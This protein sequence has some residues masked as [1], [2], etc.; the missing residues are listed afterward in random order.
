MILV[1][2]G[3]KAQL[4]KMAPIIQAL[5]KY[6]L[7][8]DF[9]LT[10]Q[11]KETMTDLIN[12]FGLPQ[13]A[14]SLTSVDEANTSKKLLHWLKTVLS[15]GLKSDS[16]IRQNGYKVCLVHGDTLS[17]LICAVL[18]KRHGI[19]IAHV[20]AGLRSFNYFHPFPEELTRLAVTKFSD[21]FYCAG[22][23]A[24]NNAERLAKADA[25]IVDIGHNTLLDSV[26][27]AHKFRSSKKA[28]EEPYAIASIHRFENLSNKARFNF[29]M[30]Q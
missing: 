27:Y 6:Q 4:V 5:E 1:P 30:E 19:K 10:G 20:E 26:Q 2:V 12:A 17:T 3:T 28:T 22:Q 11:H 23:W 29:I 13:P 15:T 16:P 14:Y 18:A 8:Y 25:K 21:I 7:P 9:I 24:Y